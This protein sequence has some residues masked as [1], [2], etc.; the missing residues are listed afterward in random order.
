M[1]HKQHGGA[2]FQNQFFNLHP[3]ENVDVI[4]RFVPHVQVGRRQQAGR[5]QHLLFLSFRVVFHLFHK[6][7]PVK[8]ELS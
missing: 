7:H 2:V 3:G 4:K 1:L 6:L 5:K 8:I